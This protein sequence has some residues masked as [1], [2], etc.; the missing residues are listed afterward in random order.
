[1]RRSP[2]NPNETFNIYLDGEKVAETENLMCTLPDVASGNHTIEIEACYIKSKSAKAAINVA[3][4]GS[5]SYASLKT[6]V[7]ANAQMGEY[8]ATL[9]IVNVSTGESISRQISVPSTFEV[10]S[11]AKGE[12]VANLS[13]SGFI[14]DTENISLNADAT[15]ELRLV[16][17]IEAPVNLSYAASTNT[18][19]WNRDAGFVEGFEDYADFTQQLDPW[20]TID[21]DGMPTYAISIGAMS[22]I[23]T[24]PE[25]RG[26]VSAMVFN[27]YNTF[28]YKA[29]DD[30]LFIAPEGDKYIMFSSAEQG[31]SDDWLISPMLNIESD[32]VLRFT[33]K[34]YTATYP[35]IVQIGVL[36]QEGETSSFELLD[37]LSLPADWSRYELGLGAYA[38]SQVQVAFH[39]VSYDAWISF[40]DDVYVG[41]EQD[42][43]VASS[44]RVQ[45]YDVFVD[46]AL[47]GSTA[48]TEYSLDSLE[49]GKHI[50]GVQA[51]YATGTSDITS[52]E[53]NITSGV[54]DI[55][56][57]NALTKVYFNLHG[58][59]VDESMLM[60][61]VYIMRSGAVAQK[62][63]IR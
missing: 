38:G 32:Y 57:D 28:P 45:R 39:H 36:T 37:A 3:V 15:V 4:P 53:V 12:Y 51:V 49:A 31:Q 25:T 35:G 5:E 10:P 56:R 50:V 61:G 46:G 43:E 27:P 24:V 9:S 54:N 63:V 21:N 26:K 20:T 60:P 47:H 18:I 17:D 41:H 34:S 42:Q 23:L 30:G 6:N 2:N 29:S 16:E 52:I 13:G 22:N 59:P 44:Q 62:V 11:L 48:T 58:Q 19:S 40:V 33:A 1:V 7:S 14:D 55:E 8:L